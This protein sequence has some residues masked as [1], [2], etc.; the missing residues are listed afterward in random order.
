MGVESTQYTNAK[1]TTKKTL[2]SGQ[3][4]LLFSSIN[5]KSSS[6]ISNISLVCFHQ[7]YSEEQSSFERDRITHGKLIMKPFILR[8]VKSEMHLH[9]ESISILHNACGLRMHA[10]VKICWTTSQMHYS[11]SRA[12][13]A[14]CFSCWPSVALGHSSDSLTDDDVPAR[15]WSSCL[16]KRSRLNFVPCPRSSRNSTALY[17][18]NWSAPVMG[19]VYIWR[20]C[21]YK[22]YWFQYMWIIVY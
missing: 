13:E 2:P 21:C 19:K 14:L 4:A 16:P 20:M 1:A 18:T 6:D 17:S 7:K 3:A 5:G 12:D 8:L 15:S 9:A 10:N 11:V 22:W